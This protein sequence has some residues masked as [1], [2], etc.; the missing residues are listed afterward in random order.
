MTWMKK[1]TP[2]QLDKLWQTAVK[3]RA[4]HISEYSGKTRDD[5]HALHGHHILGKDTY[6]LRWNL[7]NGICITGG[8]HFYIAHGST[9]RAE[10][11]KEWALKY[12]GSAKYLALKKHQVGGVDLWG[13]KLYLE[14]KIKE[15]KI[16]EAFI[17]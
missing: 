9:Q 2:K 1:P 11:F 5:G 10:K 12:N 7:D 17:Q 6:A 15:F 16:G 14:Q 4:G 3:Q 8:E 13:T